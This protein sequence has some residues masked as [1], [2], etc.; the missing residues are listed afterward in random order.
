VKVYA[1]DSAKATYALGETTGTPKA[2]VLPSEITGWS[3]SQATQ[4]VGNVLSSSIDVST[5]GTGRSVLLQRRADGSDTWTT[6][7]S[8]TTAADGTLAV[9]WQVAQGW[10]HMRLV[11][12][13]TATHG[14]VTSASRL[15][16]AQSSLSGFP[17]GS[18]SQPPGTQLTH[19]VTVS[20]GGQRDLQVQT[21]PAGTPT[22]TTHGVVT[23]DAAGKAT[24]TVPVLD[25]THEWVVR[26]SAH[27]TYGSEAAGPVSTVT[28]AV[29]APST[30]IGW[31]TTKVVKPLGTT[32]TDTVAVTTAGTARTLHVQY[33]KAG[34]TDWV[35]RDLIT[36]STTGAATVTFPVMAGSVAWR[37]HAPAT[38][39]HAAVTSAS[40]STQAQTAVSGYATTATTVAAGTAIKDG[41]TVTPGANRTVKVQYRK[42]Y[43]TTWVTYQTL[44]T[45]STGT[46]TVTLKA[47]PGA[48]AWRVHV[49]ATS[50]HGTAFTTP[51]RS[52]K[53]Q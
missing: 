6:V 3:T 36:T 51:S 19:Q 24:V 39:S 22:W 11:A 42:A 43:T 28:G 18:V 8:Y 2:A 50:K 29:A 45:S 5:S 46:T 47:F 7:K 20:P 25:G 10:N 9:S 14:A 31:D 41:I 37:V 52:V 48:H 40:R 34:T 35:T 13:A 4:P 30:V 26:T 32:V 38:A 53:G 12:P 1:L 33:R 15:V 49:P 27:P 17:G 16:V 23:T 44:V 21:R